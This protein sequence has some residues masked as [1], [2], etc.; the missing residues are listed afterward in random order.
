MYQT[1]SEG[2]GNSMSRATI[3]VLGYAPYQ[4]ILSDLE[5]TDKAMARRYARQHNQIGEYRG[6][7]VK[8]YKKEDLEGR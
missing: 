8:V 3:Y 7:G 5:F 1:Q 4:R 2:E 6:R